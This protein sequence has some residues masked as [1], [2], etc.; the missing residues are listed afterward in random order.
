MKPP[1]LSPKSV[2]ASVHCNY[3]KANI[4]N[5]IKKIDNSIYIIGGAGMDNIKDLLNEYTIYNPAIEYTLLP[6]TKYLPQMEKPAEFVST[7]K[8]FFS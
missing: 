1:N 4:V 6:D 8:M 3:T 7:V 5:A 2:Y